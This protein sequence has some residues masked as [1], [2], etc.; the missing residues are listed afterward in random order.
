MKYEQSPLEKLWKLCLKIRFRIRIR[1]YHYNWY[2]RG[3]FTLTKRNNEN[4]FMYL[5]SAILKETRAGNTVIVKHSNIT[6]RT[7]VLKI[8][9][10]FYAKRRFLLCFSGASF[11]LSGF[12]RSSSIKYFPLQEI[13]D[14]DKNCIS[15]HPPDDSQARRERKG[16]V[17]YAALPLS[18]AHEH[19]D[20]YLQL[21][22]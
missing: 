1:I 3:L 4:A 18:P 12:M 14:I 13:I 11:D 7:A 21:C 9:V 5:S 22:M 20:I 8:C 16:T 17:S 15:K 10:I 2:S 6:Q 19:S